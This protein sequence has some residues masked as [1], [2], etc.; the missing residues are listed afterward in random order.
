MHEY[1]PF[2]DAAFDNLIKILKEE[3]NIFRFGIHEGVDEVFECGVVLEMFEMGG[4]CDDW[5]VG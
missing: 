4:G 5:M 1:S 2:L 3:R